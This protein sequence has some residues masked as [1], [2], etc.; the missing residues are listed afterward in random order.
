MDYGIGQHRSA[1]FSSCQTS[2]EAFTKKRGSHYVYRTFRNLPFHLFECLSLTL[3][4]SPSLFHCLP[5]SLSVFF[6][7]HSPQLLPPLCYNPQISTIFCSLTLSHNLIPSF[8]PTLPLSLYYYV[9]KTYSSPMNF[10]LKK[11]KIFYDFCLL[12]C[13]SL[14]NNP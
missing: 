10:G 14:T 3:F 13:S 9:N 4:L 11:A 8:Y 1:N 7:T 6:L 5:L 2:K 12:S